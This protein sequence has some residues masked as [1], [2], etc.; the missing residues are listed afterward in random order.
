MTH[1]PHPMKIII[2]PRGICGVLWLWDYCHFTTDD[3]HFQRL[4]HRST[5]YRSAQVGVCGSNAVDRAELLRKLSNRKWSQCWTNEM[6]RNRK[7]FRNRWCCWLIGVMY[8]NL[9]EEGRGSDFRRHFKN[10]CEC[11]RPIPISEMSSAFSSATGCGRRFRIPKYEINVLD[12]MVCI[13]FV[14]W[15][16]HHPFHIHTNLSWKESPISI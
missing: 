14:P 7:W 5:F 13:W 15:I 16:H 12:L 8:M 3:Q 6:D 11:R 4:T 10:C 1:Y 9:F 2:R